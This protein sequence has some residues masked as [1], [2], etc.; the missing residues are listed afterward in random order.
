MRLS[1][2]VV[3]RYLAKIGRVIRVDKHGI[4]QLAKELEVYLARKTPPAPWGNR[5]LLRGHPFQIRAVDGSIREVFIQIKSVETDNPYYVVSGGLGYAQGK[6]VVVVFVNGSLDVKNP[7]ANRS[8]Q[9]QLYPVLLHELTHAADKFT[10]G[11]GEELT[12]EEARDNDRYYNHPTEVRAYL[13]EILHE[14]DHMLPHIGNL[15]KVLYPNM[16]EALRVVLNQS[17]TWEEI[18]PHLTYRNKKLIMKAVAQ[19]YEDYL[20]QESER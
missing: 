8:V 7:A 14:I 2:L 11:V 6:P 19:E 15:R 1:E 12:E 3:S 20:T 16:G 13:Q 9:N 5:M 18:E 17:K 4:K 10:Q